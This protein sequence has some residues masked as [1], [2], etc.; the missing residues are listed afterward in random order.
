LFDEIPKSTATGI[1]AFT[2][3]RTRIENMPKGSLRTSLLAEVNS[4]SG[5]MDRAR[6]N[7][8][9]WFDDSM[10]R[11]S[12]WYTRKTRM[13]GLIL[14]IIVVVVIN[15][16]TLM[17]ANTLV[18][19]DAKR[20]ALVEAAGNPDFPEAKLKQWEDLGLPIGWSLS[21]PERGFPTDGALVGKVIGLLITGLAVSLGAPFWFGFLSRLMSARQGLR[22]G[23]APP[24]PSQPRLNR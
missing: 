8:E 17:I 14:A 1:N 10:D 6:D 22:Q 4:A 24:Q 12:G 15:A 23:G 21:D 19:D 2:T 20:D 16:D 13:M 5:D 9:K 3:L 18:K 7:I 11:V